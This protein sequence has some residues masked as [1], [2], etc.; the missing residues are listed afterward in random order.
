MMTYLPLYEILYKNL[1]SKSLSSKKNYLLKYSCH[2][3]LYQ[4]QVYN[5]V[6][7]HLYTL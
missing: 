2:T 3:T 6:V 7:Q 4:F 1:G 5:T